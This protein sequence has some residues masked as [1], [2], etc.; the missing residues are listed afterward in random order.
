MFLTGDE[1]R[2][3]VESGLVSGYVDLDTQIQP[4]GFD[5]TAAEIHSFGGAGRLDF[6]NSEREIPETKKIEPESE[7]EDDA[8]G[9]WRLSRGCYKVVM[10]ERVD[11]P[12]DIVAVA[13]PRSSLLRMGATTE[14]A[15]WDSGY[16][17]GGAFMLNVENPEG[18]EIKENARINQL[19]FVR[20]DESEEAYS[21]VYGD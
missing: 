13:F 6:S 9:W 8:Y 18:V 15:F 10:N 17:G 21:G 4:N 3:E 1:L 11:I 5:L 2:K 12:N 16:S 7:G 19:G 20:V 14:N